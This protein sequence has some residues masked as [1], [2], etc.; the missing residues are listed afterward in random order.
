MY[1]LKVLGPWIKKKSSRPNIKHP[2]KSIRKSGIFRCSPKIWNRKMNWTKKNKFI[3]G[4]VFTPWFISSNEIASAVTDA[5]I[6]QKINFRFPCSH[7]H[8]YI[9]SNN[10]TTADV[11]DRWSNN[12]NFKPWSLKNCSVTKVTRSFYSG[13]TMTG[14][15]IWCISNCCVICHSSAIL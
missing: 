3:T 7:F 1:E 12:I 11:D 9:P 14:T 15:W 4:H 6:T 2:K 8:W 13:R 5:T 10:R